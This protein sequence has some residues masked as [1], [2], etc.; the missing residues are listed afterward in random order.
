MIKPTEL[1]PHV[2]AVFRDLLPK[3]LD[4]ECYR[5]ITGDAT[6]VSSLL[7]CRWDKIFFTGS[8]RVGKI[9]LQAAAEYL[10][11]VTLE[12]GGKSPVII[13]RDIV[14]LEVVARRI[15][16]GKALNCG[17]VCVAPDFVFCHEKVSPFT[18]L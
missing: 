1:T 7:K 14:D 3:Y 2:E 15:V 18:V 13:N 16:W 11:P 17:Q 6:V 10:T 9:V 8:T 12:L 4:Q 5:V